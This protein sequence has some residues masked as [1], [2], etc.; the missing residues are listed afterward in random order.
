MA[1]IAHFHLF[2]NKIGHDTVIFTTRCK[3]QAK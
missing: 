2:T 3:I 1:T